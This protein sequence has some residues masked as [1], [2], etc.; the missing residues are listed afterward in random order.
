MLDRCVDLAIESLQQAEAKGTSSTE[1][2]ALADAW[3]EMSRRKDAWARRFREAVRN[4]A[5]EFLNPTESDF[6]PLMPSARSKPSLSLVDDDQ[7]VQA[8]SSARLKQMLLPVVEHALNDLDSLMST[9]L[10]FDEVRPHRNPLQP[11]LFAKALQPLLEEAESPEQAAVWSRHLGAPLGKELNQLYGALVKTLQ[12]ANVQAAT[13]RLLPVA[14]GGR[15]AAPRQG[16]PSGFGGLGRGGG[17]GGGSGGGAT[18]GGASGGAAG[19]GGSA[20]SHAGADG[21]GGSA[22]GSAAG[23]T[24]GPGA[25]GQ[26]GGA[27]RQG[28]GGAG[29]GEA[30][31]MP[32]G[33]WAD[34]SGC[35]LG[36][37]LLQD[38]LY[39]GGGAQAQAPLQHAYYE[40]VDQELDRLARDPVR[41]DEVFNPAEVERHLHLPPVD[42]PMRHVG[43]ESPLSPE[44]WGRWGA[45][46]ERALTRNKLKRQAEKVGQVLG[47]EVVRKL[48]HQVAQDPRL[49]APVRE[50]I[51]ALEPSLLKL[52]LA[53]PRYFSDEEHPARR[54][55]ER[56]AERSFK[57]NDEASGAFG[58]FLQPV[59][60][61]VNDLNQTPEIPDAQPF[62]EALATLETSWKH[63]DEQEDKQRAELLDSVRFAEKRQAEADQIAWELSQ[64]SDLG[65]APAVVQDFLFGPWA[66]VM[67][68]AR[69]NAGPGQLDPGGYGGIV[70]D[71]LWSV[72]REET[73]RQPARLFEILPGTIGKLRE[74]LAMLGHDPSESKSFFGALE[75]LHSPVLKLRARSRRSA[76]EATPSEAAPLEALAAPE[77][78][79]APSPARKPKTSE[80]FW[81]GRRELGAAGYA[82]TLPTDHVD[83]IELRERAQQADLDVAPPPALVP[84][85]ESLVASLREGSWVDLYSRSEW[86]R[87]RLVWAGTK[88]SLFMFVSGGGQPHTM[89]RRSCLRLVR[90][91]L[92]RPVDMHGVVETALRSA[93]AEPAPGGR[94]SRSRPD[95]RPGELVPAGLAFAPAAAASAATSALHG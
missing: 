72:K 50:A 18:G 91:R 87:A 68:Q 41:P 95:S 26:G 81:M 88:G 65:G 1:R 55:V 38:F 9:A 3:S 16:A 79:I 90:E 6:A 17:G 48:V 40:Q 44:T 62:A 56:V 33:G 57:Y 60:G 12:G 42:R 5:Q 64:R 69:L 43:V 11:E 15:A 58:S 39:R 27:N 23:A 32:P 52:A 66:L 71:L 89:T 82:D 19:P 70:T 61:L 37:P 30:M 54:L 24:P 31:P 7:V 2:R 73:L 83:L 67:A 49:L 4:G 22:H 74:G 47:L 92:L 35:D 53:D 63:Q 51:V 45:P 25:S 93:G 28:A 36:S 20:A 75:A 94:S 78:D 84:D 14:G 29:G 21:P 77:A 85:A 76:G 13:Y 59:A 8:I 86:L 46:R 34:L 10:G 80:E